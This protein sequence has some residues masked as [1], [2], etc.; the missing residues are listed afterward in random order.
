LQGIAPLAW[1]DRYGSR[2]EHDH[3]PKTEAARKELATVIRMDGKILLDALDTTT[4]H[5][6]VQEL[7]AVS[8]LRQVWAE[9][10]VN[11]DGTLVWREVKNMPSPAELMTSPYDTGAPV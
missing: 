7:P 8:T 10:Y 4:E 6:W 9:P 5:R 3:L 2:V 1:Y 11:V